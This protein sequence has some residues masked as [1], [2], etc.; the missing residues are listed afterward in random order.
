MPWFK[1]DDGFHG[2]PKIVE[3]SLG[4]VGLWT[5][6]GSWCANYLTDGE[7]RFNAIR[8]LGGDL[9]QVQE[10]VDADLWVP[11]GSEIYRFKDWEDYQPLKADVEAEREAAQS[12][13]RAQ[14]AKK[15]GVQPNT[16]DSS[17][18]VQA[19]NTGTF[20]DSSGEVQVPR[21]SPSTDPAQPDP[22]EPA[23]RSL[24]TTEFEHVYELYPL[25]AS[26]GAAFKAFQKAKKKIAISEIADAVARYRDDPNRDPKFTKHFA[27]WL[28]QGCWDD[29]PLPPRTG[30]QP[31]AADERFQRNLQL[32]QELQDPGT[33][34]IGGGHGGA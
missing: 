30:N 26:K 23:S 12:R 5:L 2:H 28:N 16:A 24:Y 1:V 25:K 3:L 4:A 13:M 10:L 11:I 17:G 22:E 20:A 33:F 9:D 6:T 18:E 8:R 34:Q 29:D 21:P 31:S 27:T 7:I 15:K 32:V 14:R 19:N